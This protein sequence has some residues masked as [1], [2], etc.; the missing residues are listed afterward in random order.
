GLPTVQSLEIRAARLRDA[1]ASRDRPFMCELY[2]VPKSGKSSTASSMRTFF[3]RNGF[4]IDIP[5]EGATAVKLPRVEPGINFAYTEYALAESRRIIATGIY[6]V[7]ILDRAIWDGV[8]R[9][10]HYEHSGQLTT[11]QADA[12][13]TYFLM[14]HNTEMFDACICLMVDPAV[15]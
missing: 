4:S 12:A 14:P 5:E 6:D 15:G 7:G 11:K 1:R 9:M 13:S 8:V 10:H 3:R 2:G